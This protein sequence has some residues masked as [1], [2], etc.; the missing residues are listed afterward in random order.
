MPTST[1]ASVLWSIA[2]QRWHFTVYLGTV[3][4]VH[5]GCTGAGKLWKGENPGRG[6][7]KNCL[8]RNNT[9]NHTKT[10]KQKTQKKGGKER[11]G[12]AANKTWLCTSI[13]CKGYAAQTCHQKEPAF[14]LSDINTGFAF[15][16]SALKCGSLI[17]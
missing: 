7:L 6:I 14:P 17:Q 8:K 11:K 3:T 4:S 10:N 1:A 9:Q 12:R 15:K 2:S 13:S 16:S 5:S